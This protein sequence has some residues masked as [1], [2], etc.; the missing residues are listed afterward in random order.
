MPTVKRI[1]FLWA[2]EAA[3]TKEKM[4]YAANKDRFMKR[5]GGID[6]EIQTNDFSELDYNV[7][8]AKVMAGGRFVPLP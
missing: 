6:V 4:K 8:R 2:P 7:V 3:S 1:F 5:L